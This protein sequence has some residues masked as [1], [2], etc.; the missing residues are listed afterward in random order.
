[1]VELKDAELAELRKKIDIVDNQI[2]ELV[3]DRLELADKVA[4]VKKKKSMPLRDLAREEEVIRNKCEKTDLPEEFV[5]KL[6]RLIIDE[7]VK[8]EEKKIK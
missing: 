2:L 5:R 4:Q 1:M 7:A 6:Y 8:L 3:E